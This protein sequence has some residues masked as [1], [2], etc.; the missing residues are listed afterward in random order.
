MLILLLPLWLHVRRDFEQCWKISIIDIDSSNN[1]SIV[2]NQSFHFFLRMFAEYSLFI[3]MF[4]KILTTWVTWQFAF[5]EILNN[6]Y[7]EPVLQ[8]ITLDSA[9]WKKRDKKQV[10]LEK[11]ATQK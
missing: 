10:Q 2:F 7:E 6:T 9:T 8:K 1:A 3:W 5:T 4:E 11:S